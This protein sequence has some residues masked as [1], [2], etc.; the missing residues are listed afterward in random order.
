[1]RNQRDIWTG[2]TWV[3]FALLAVLLILPLGRLL[4]ASLLDKGGGLTLAHY[5][6]FLGYPYYSRTIGHS[7]LV[8]DQ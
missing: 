4:W 8:N 1:M 7:F 2:V 6:D 5:R 3:A